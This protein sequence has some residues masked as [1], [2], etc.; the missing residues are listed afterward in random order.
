MLYQILNA[1]PQTAPIYNSISQIDIQWKAAYGGYSMAS[2]M[3][4]SDSRTCVLKSD[5]DQSL[6]CNN[7]NSTV[8][9][10]SEWFNMTTQVKAITL[11]HNGGCI[12]TTNNTMKCTDDIQYPNWQQDDQD[13]T[14]FS[15]IV[16]SATTQPDKYW[17]VCVVSQKDGILCKDRQFQGRDWFSPRGGRLQQA[18]MD[19]LRI[20]GVLSNQVYCAENVLDSTDESKW[21]QYGNLPISQVSTS[22]SNMCGVYNNTAY[23]YSRHTKDWSQISGVGAIYVQLVGDV[24]YR[25]SPD[26]QVSY[27][28]LDFNSTLGE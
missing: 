7:A 6:F 11:N 22:G 24:L 12:L 1:I 17:I 18:S 8:A 13:L 2:K 15:D 27:G 19:Q 23:C 28:I 21:I 20:C 4:F 9:K 14:G 5:V 16:T 25:I 26:N 10:L 3:A